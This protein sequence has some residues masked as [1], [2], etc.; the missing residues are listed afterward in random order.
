MKSMLY[1]PAEEEAVGR[2]SKC[3]YSSDQDI[4]RV[5]RFQLHRPI[6][7]AACA[8]RSSLCWRSRSRCSSEFSIAEAT[9]RPRSSASCTSSLEKQC[10]AAHDKRIAPMMRPR[11]I[12]G[13]VRLHEMQRARTAA[14]WL[15]SHEDG[16]HD[17][18]AA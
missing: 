11:E 1:V 7:A 16:A 8:N 2:P 17:W 14:R 15:G 9:R 13:T 5:T 12:R 18:G 10:P 4:S 3:L 6:R